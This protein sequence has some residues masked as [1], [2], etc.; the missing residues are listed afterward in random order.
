[1]SLP[2]RIRLRDLKGESGALDASSSRASQ[3]WLALVRDS[4]AIVGECGESGKEQG[5]LVDVAHSIVQKVWQSVQQL[6][7]S[8]QPLSKSKIDRCDFPRNDTRLA[9]ASP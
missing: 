1:M 2:L 6:V 5:K 9:Y 4:R 3:K 8:K 7:A